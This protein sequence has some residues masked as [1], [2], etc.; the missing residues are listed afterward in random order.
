MTFQSNLK[1][2]FI[3]DLYKISECNQ[4]NLLYC[5]NLIGSNKLV[6]YIPDYDNIFDDNNPEEQNL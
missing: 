6:S 5:T 1:Y 2:Y 3:C 4:S